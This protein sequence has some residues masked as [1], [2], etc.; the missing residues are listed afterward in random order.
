MSAK[1]FSDDFLDEMREVG[2]P[3]ADATIAE[4][5]DGHDVGAVNKVMKTLIANDGVPT[6]KLPRAV[7]GYL[8][9]TDDLPPWADP[10]RIA[11]GE[12]FFEIHG[13]ACVMSLACASLPACY[14]SRRGVQVLALTARLQSDPVRRIGETAQ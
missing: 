13:P 12:R 4:I 1:T 5:F 10:E 11:I 9:D 2:D 7:R 8:D 6:K 14:G 3:P